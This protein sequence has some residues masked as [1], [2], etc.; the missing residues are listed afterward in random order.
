MVHLTAAED[1]MYVPPGDGPLT[2]GWMLTNTSPGLVRRA[3][4]R[5]T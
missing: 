5:R 3:R 4:C 1:A 2:G